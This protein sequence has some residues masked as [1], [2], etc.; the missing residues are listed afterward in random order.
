M[1]SLP[2]RPAA[3]LLDFDGVIVVERVVAV[4]K[5]NGTAR[6]PACSAAWLAISRYAWSSGA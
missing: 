1:P 3:L 2:Q 6:R 5:R 4:G